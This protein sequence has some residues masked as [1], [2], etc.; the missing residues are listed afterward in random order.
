[1]DVSEPRAGFTPQV[2]AAIGELPA[3]FLAKYP[4]RF[5]FSVA[6]QE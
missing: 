6:A 4:I 1:M 5:E 2:V 3:I